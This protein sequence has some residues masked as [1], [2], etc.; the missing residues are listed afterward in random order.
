MMLPVQASFSRSPAHSRIVKIKPVY[1][2]WNKKTINDFSPESINTLYNDGYVFTR[3][4]KGDMIQTRSLRIDLS[5]FDISSENRRIL[6]KTDQL[7]TN[8][9]SSLPT[10]NYHWSIGK[11][12]HDF[13][14]TKFGK[15][16]FSA[17][18]AKELFTDKTKSNFNSLFEYRNE[19]QT[20]GYAICYENSLILH[21]AYPFYE[22]GTVNSELK[23][24]GMSMMLQA[25]LSAKERGLKY[26]YLGSAQRPTDTY[27]L[28]FSGIEWFQEKNWSKNTEELKSFI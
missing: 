24:I 11:M 22:L 6:R 18:K 3:T 27:K 23:N 5:Q 19:N 7:L 12:A 26:I 17:N 8:I 25:I 1:L 28:Q 13:Y 21:Y 9:H 15:G 4:G 10:D 20:I 16:T 14:E 2:I